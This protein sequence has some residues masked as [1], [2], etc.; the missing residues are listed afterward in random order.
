[1]EKSDF[2]KMIGLFKSELEKAALAYGLELSEKQVEDFGLYYEMLLDYNERVNLTAITEPG[3][4]A[5]KH[6]IDSLSC[7]ESDI[8]PDGVSVIDVGTGAGFPGVALKIFRPGLKLTLMDSLKKRL[9]FLEAVAKA[10]NINAAMIHSRAETAGQNKAHREKYDLAVSR[11]VAKLSVL[12]EYCLPLVKVG[13]YFVAL[14]GASYETEIA[15]AEKAISALGGSLAK[16]TPITLPFLPD[17][18][19]VI[20]LKKITPTPKTYPRREGI[21]SK[22]PLDFCQK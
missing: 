20:Y 18:R 10:L 22:N 1:L 19:A 5:V 21:P 4:V 3:E 17:K 7:Y 11:A 9:V 16:I 8:F 13:G 12:A 14:K 2:E 6:I 15:E